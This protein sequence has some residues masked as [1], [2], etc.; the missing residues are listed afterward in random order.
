[1]NVEL[2]TLIWHYLNYQRSSQPSSWSCNMFQ[3]E[4]ISHQVCRNMAGRRMVNNSGLRGKEG[5][6]RWRWYLIQRVSLSY[7][8]GHSR[9]SGLK[10]CRQWMTV[11][12]YSEVGW[13]LIATSIPK[14]EISDLDLFFQVGFMNLQHQH[15]VELLSNAESQALLA[16]IQMIFMTDISFQRYNPKCCIGQGDTK[17]VP[18]GGC[19]GEGEW[20]RAEMGQDGT[21]ENIFGKGMGSSLGSLRVLENGWGP[22]LKGCHELCF[23]ISLNIY[24][25]SK[26][27]NFCSWLASLHVLMLQHWVR[28]FLFS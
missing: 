20:Q 5:S 11:K 18:V 16:R 28:C 13:I 1:M 21:G 19:S 26:Y 15:G 25:L 2:W 23:M 7:A 9:D 17:T 4:R 8:K 6:W 24:E 14:W 22:F 27:W 12:V 3:K 10:F